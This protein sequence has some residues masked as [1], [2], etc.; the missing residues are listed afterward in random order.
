MRSGLEMLD[1]N[2]ALMEGGA[3]QQARIAKSS[4]QDLDWTLITMSSVVCLSFFNAVCYS[5][6]PSLALV[7]SSP[8]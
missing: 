5:H 6:G 8:S 4:C 1:G 2:S 3:T 7:S